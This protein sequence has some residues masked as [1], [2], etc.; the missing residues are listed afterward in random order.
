MYNFRK[1][2]QDPNSGE[3]KHDI[4]RKVSLLYSFLMSCLVLSFV[5]FVSSCRVFLLVFLFFGHPPSLFLRSTAVEA[6]YFVVVIPFVAA[7][8]PPYKARTWKHVAFFFSL[9]R[10]V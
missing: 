3:F 1:V 5:V 9:S 10:T 4:F 2:V 8:P 7:L 6:E